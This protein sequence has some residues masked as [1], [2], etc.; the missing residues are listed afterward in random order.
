MIIAKKKP[1]TTAIVKKATA[2]AGP[3]R[4][5]GHKARFLCALFAAQEKAKLD[6][7]QLAAKIK[8]EYPDSDRDWLRVMPAVRRHYNGGRFAC[9]D[10]K[11][12]QPARRWEGGKPW[13]RHPEKPTTK[14]KPAARKTKAA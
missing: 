1:A 9:Q 2:P 12:A 11:P 10:R 6:D 3:D 13:T 5:Q 14:S 4:R 8:A 7:A